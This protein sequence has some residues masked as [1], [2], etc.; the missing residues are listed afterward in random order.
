M[1]D[2]RTSHSFQSKH[3]T[4]QD[5]IPVF[6]LSFF[7]F[8]QFSHCIVFFFQQLEFDNCENDPEHLKFI[9]GR[10]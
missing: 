10:R 9:P 2:A 6:L 8:S 5:K 3:T 7:F 4:D 1:P